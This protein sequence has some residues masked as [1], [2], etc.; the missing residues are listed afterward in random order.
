[1]PSILNRI[2][3]MRAMH[4]KLTRTAPISHHHP[5]CVIRP[6]SVRRRVG[7]ELLRSDED[8]EDEVNRV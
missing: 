5:A 2:A 7:L 8:G 3:T 4:T 6:F 1:L